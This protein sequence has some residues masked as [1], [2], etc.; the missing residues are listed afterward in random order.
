MASCEK[1]KVRR[2]EWS[3]A[4][5]AKLSR[6]G[7]DDIDEIKAQVEQGAVIFEFENLALAVCRIDQLNTR[8][9]FVIVCLEGRGLHKIAPFLIGMAKRAGCHSIRVHTQRKGLSKMLERY[10]FKQDEIVLKKVL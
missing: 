2:V 6:S 3:L 9:E 4:V 1:I 8:S 10:Q 5:A 7:G